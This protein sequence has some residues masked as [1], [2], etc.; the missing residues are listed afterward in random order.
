[1]VSREHLSVDEVAK[2]CKAITEAVQASTVMAGGKR[3][4]VYLKARDVAQLLR[5]PSHKVSAVFQLLRDILPFM[6]W[7]QLARVPAHKV[8]AV[9]VLLWSNSPF[10]QCAEVE[11]CRNLTVKLQSKTNGGGNW[12]IEKT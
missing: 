2:V 9:F 7:A 3:K 4:P 12:K 11:A 6:R 8:S 10:M 5:M 1:M